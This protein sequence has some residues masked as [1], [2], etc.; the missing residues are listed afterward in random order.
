MEVAAYTR[1][2]TLEQSQHGSSLEAQEARIRA[3]AL[4]RDA[5]IVRVY[6]DDGYSGKNTNRPAFRRMLDDLAAGDFDCIVVSRLDR[7]TRKQRDFY[8]LLDEAERHNVSIATADQHVDTSTPAGRLLRGMLLEVATF[9]RELIGERVREVMQRRAERGLWNGARVPL[10]YRHVPESKSIEPDPATAPLVK[11]IFERYAGGESSDAIARAFNDLG[12]RTSKRQVLTVLR[13]AT[14]IG[15]MPW[16]GKVY[17]STH[18]PLIEPALFEAVQR[19]LAANG[20][21]QP[22]P[23]QTAK[24]Y[25]YIL[26]GILYCGVC[27]KHLTTSSAR[28]KGQRYP[29]YRCTGETQKLGCRQR[30]INAQVLDSFVVDRILETALNPGTLRRAQELYDARTDEARQRIE[31][32]LAFARSELRDVESRRENCVDLAQR[33]MVAPENQAEW[34]AELAKLSKIRDNLR[35]RKEALED[36]LA[37]QDRARGDQPP[38]ED[39]I[40]DVAE[41]LKNEDAARQRRAL[42]RSIVSRVNYSPDEIEITYRPTLGF[43]GAARM[44][45]PMRPAAKL[46]W[47]IQ[48]RRACKVSLAVIR[49]DPSRSRRSPGCC[50]R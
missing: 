41:R 1:V 16:K 45:P 44:A 9:E 48:S 24:R 7:L 13:N 2:S 33:G 21:L 49:D 14:Y 34:N 40:Q 25:D 5:Q 46:R 22:G 8:N 36:E 17:P 37:A 23:R 15:A 43:V 11:E 19:R 10:G 3:W 31:E 30:P 20:Q 26:D 38:L 47:T 12:R 42:V 28:A 50:A 35:L 18:Q 39:V 27:G 6:N 4:A 29:Y 32:Q